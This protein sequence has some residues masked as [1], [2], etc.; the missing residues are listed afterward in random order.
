M[1]KNMPGRI[2]LGTDGA[3]KLAKHIQSQQ[4]WWALAPEISAILTRQRIEDRYKL[5]EKQREQNKNERH[6]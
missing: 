4:Q 3:S 6:F 5:L 2:V 1:A